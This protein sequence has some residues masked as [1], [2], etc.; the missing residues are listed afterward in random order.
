MRSHVDKDRLFSFFQE[1]G[2]RS[3]GPGRIYIVGGS[4][5]L[6]L[7]IRDQTIDIDIKLD[8]EPKGVFESIAI[9]K[10]SLSIN[11]ELAS[12]DQFVP[13]LGSWRERSEFIGKFGEVEFFHYDFYGQ[14]FA[15]IV[16]GHSVDLS[17]VSALVRLGK[18]ELGQLHAL[19]QDALPDIVRYP[20]LNQVEVLKRVDEFI[21]GKE[22]NEH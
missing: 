22:N 7:G 21:A 5:A 18:I 13:P 3:Q 4:T 2:C 11:I 8:P 16:R 17:D 20:A 9:I 10:D 12:P 15:K 19:V 6:L 14:A 1:I